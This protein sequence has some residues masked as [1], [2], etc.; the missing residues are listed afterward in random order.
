LVGH[1]ARETGLNGETFEQKALTNS[2]SAVATRPEPENDY[3][4]AAAHQDGQE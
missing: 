4:G 3:G 1:N 2:A